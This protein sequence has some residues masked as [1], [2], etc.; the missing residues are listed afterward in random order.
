VLLV[1]SHSEGGIG[2]H[3]RFLAERLPQFGLAVTVCAPA[4]T[5]AGLDLTP[6]AGP[7]VVVAVAAPIGQSGPSALRT[8]RRVLRSLV[9]DADVV[10]AHGL[11]AGADCAAFAVGRPLV[12]TWHNAAAGGR[13]RRLAHGLL[14][15]FVARR[16]ALTLAASADLTEAALRAGAHPVRDVFVV[17][18]AL[19]AAGRSRAQVREEL[20]VANRPLI[21]A[22]GRLNDQKRFDVL[23]DAAAGWPRWRDPSADPADG[24]VVV[25]A[26]DGPARGQLTARI[27]ASSAPVRLLGARSD[28]AEL[29]LAADVVA[30][31]SRWEARA[32]VAQEALRA[33][34][35]LVTTPVG[36][37]PELV[38]DAALLVGVGDV[39]GLRTAIERL[40]TDAGLRERMITLG[41]ARAASW[42]DETDCLNELIE[43]YLNLS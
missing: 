36:G 16:S 37:L 31:P 15:R 21:L 10:H 5:L 11:R 28:V 26:G 29:L 40:L 9:A 33:G 17:A 2:R 32:L 34:V 20:G 41:L 38:G 43:I 4:E 1:M 42:P 14:S 19:P 25:I 23:V 12:V 18:P 27:G 24:P 39:R 3:V 6:Q 22:V 13:A 30:L 35:P 8:S 7:A